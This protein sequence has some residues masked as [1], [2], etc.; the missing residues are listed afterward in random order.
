[1]VFEEE[2]GDNHS[3][4]GDKMEAIE[5]IAEGRMSVSG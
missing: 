1:M 4:N 2:A 3:E 5:K